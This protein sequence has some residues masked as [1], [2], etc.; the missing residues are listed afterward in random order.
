MLECLVFTESHQTE[1]SMSM[2][3]LFALYLS[4]MDFIFK[5]LALV[6]KSSGGLL[7]TTKQVKQVSIYMT[8]L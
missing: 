7:Y 6:Y 2:C 5:M 4:A 8:L 3:C 1:Y